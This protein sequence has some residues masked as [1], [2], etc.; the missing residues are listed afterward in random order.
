[1]Y[2]ALMIGKE[3]IAYNDKNHVSDE[4]LERLLSFLF[5]LKRRLLK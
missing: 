1:M 3:T 4:F 2:A 5:E